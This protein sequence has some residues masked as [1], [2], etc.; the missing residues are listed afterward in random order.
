MFTKTAD[1][2]KQTAE[3]EASGHRRWRRSNPLHQPQPALGLDVRIQPRQSWVVG[4]DYPHAAEARRP[5]RQHRGLADAL[6]ALVV[7]VAEPRGARDP[8]DAALQPTSS[9]RS[10]IH[11]PSTI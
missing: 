7:S 8:V 11:R 4:A 2:W 1:R 10:P 5:L 9:C 3:L 6:A